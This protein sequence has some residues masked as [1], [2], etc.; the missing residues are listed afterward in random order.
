[1]RLYLLI[2]AWWASFSVES[3]QLGIKHSH[4]GIVGPTF[5]PY[6]QIC[7]LQNGVFGHLVGSFDYLL[8]CGSILGAPAIE[9]YHQLASMSPFEGMI[10]AGSSVSAPLSSICQAPVELAASIRR[11]ECRSRCSGS[12]SSD[13]WRSVSTVRLSPR[14]SCA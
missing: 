8:N 5:L 3:V 6:S 12:L 1:M 9:L 2:S 10:G 7:C 13:A 4:N 11:S 14:G